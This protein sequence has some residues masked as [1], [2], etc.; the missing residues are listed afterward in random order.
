MY[1]LF[2][3]LGNVEFVSGLV[4]LVNIFFILLIESEVFVC[5]S[6][7][8]I[9]DICGFVI[10]VLFYLFLYV[11]LGMEDWIFMFGVEIFGFIL[12]YGDGF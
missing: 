8:V 6:S 12:L 3:E 9:V 1:L 4:V 2:G 11:W 10:D 5:F 7:V